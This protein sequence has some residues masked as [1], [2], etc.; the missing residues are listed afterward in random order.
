MKKIVSAVA[1]A[2]MAAG[3]ATAD[4][5]I[6]TNYR[7]GTNLLTVNP[8]EGGAADV[9]GFNDL[10]KTAWDDDT[11]I[12]AAGEH[13]GIVYVL[14]TSESSL[15]MNYGYAWLNWG[16]FTLFGGTRD[17]RGFMKRA[18]PLDGNWWNNYCEFAKPGLHKAV[19]FGLD[20]GNVTGDQA[21]KKAV[22]FTTAFA[23]NDDAN[24]NVAFFKNKTGEKVFDYFNAAA[25]F[26]FKQE[27]FILNVT[28]KYN[29]NAA[30]DADDDDWSVG[31]YANLLVVDGLDNLIGLTFAKDEDS[32]ISD[33]VFVGIDLRLAY[34]LDAL[35]LYTLNNLTLNDGDMISWHTLGA[36]YKVS[37]VISAVG[38]QMIINSDENPWS[39]ASDAGNKKEYIA[40]RP[41]ID[42]TAQKNAVLS[43]GAELKF[44][45]FMKASGEDIDFA[46]TVPMVMRV[47]L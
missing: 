19:G 9:Q 37:D 42:L 30:T 12:S 44:T 46:F 23:I 47:K 8:G 29:H 45:N 32:K 16:N 10:T 34:K 35:N 25:Q 36:A 43:I 22:N 1:I 41:Y 31:A 3:L 15:G 17:E 38:A 21:G 7:L 40:V 14:K 2:A 5:K 24:V 28:G 6:S 4:V 13:A 26:N 18:N 27:A 39:N 11:K 20:A 33:K